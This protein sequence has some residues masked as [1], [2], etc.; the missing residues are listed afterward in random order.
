MSVAFGTHLWPGLK[1]HCPRRPF[2]RR[3]PA[4]AVKKSGLRI[5][6]MAREFTFPTTCERRLGSL[7][8]PPSTPVGT[9]RMDE[10]RNS[11][12]HGQALDEKSIRD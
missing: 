5:C 8:N 12:S 6:Q 9:H 11:D 7:S 2:I 4:E 3:N 1:S 10:Q